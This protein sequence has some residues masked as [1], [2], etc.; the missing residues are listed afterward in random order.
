MQK[1]AGATL[2]FLLELRGNGNCYLV[3]NFSEKV[4]ASVILIFLE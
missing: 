4:V 1:N 3:N 2:A